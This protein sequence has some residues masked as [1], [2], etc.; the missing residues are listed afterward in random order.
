MQ[1]HDS[2]VSQRFYCCMLSA[3]RN[4][5]MVLLEETTT[6]ISV[7]P[8]TRDNRTANADGFI[9]TTIKPN[10]SPVNG[11]VRPFTSEGNETSPAKHQQHFLVW[12]SVHQKFVPSGQTVNQHYYQEVLRQWDQANA[13]QFYLKTKI[14]WKRTVKLKK[15]NI[16]SFL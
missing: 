12:G 1:P 7:L 4:F 16:H 9:V 5:L 3:F 15:I 10:S 2:S 13:A 6:L 11:K 8:W 14:K